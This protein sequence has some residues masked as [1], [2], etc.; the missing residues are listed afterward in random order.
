MKNWN[1]IL[2]TVPSMPYT[3]YVKVDEEVGV[4]TPLQPLIHT[5]LGPGNR[6]LMKPT[7]LS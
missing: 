2:T 5:P 3:I 7:A 1:L 4:I 6:K